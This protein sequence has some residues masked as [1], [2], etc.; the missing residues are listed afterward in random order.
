MIEDSMRHH[1]LLINP[2]IYD[3]TAYDLWYRPLGLLYIASLLRING[4]SISC[5]DC[6]DTDHPDIRGEPHLKMPKRKS[7]GE[8]SYASER[9]PKPPPLRFRTAI[10]DVTA[11]LPVFF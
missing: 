11:L 6:L 7:S 10:I 2:W 8:G 4:A 3:F 1:I 5:M 9:I